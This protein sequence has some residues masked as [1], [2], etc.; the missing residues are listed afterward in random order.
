MSKSRKKSEN[1][2]DKYE[3]LIDDSKNE[4][5]ILK[6]YVS[7]NSPQSDRA[8][9]NLKK[10]CEENLKG[11]YALEIIDLYQKPELAKEANLIVVP[12]L[13]KKLPLPIRRLIGDL[14]NI[15]SV[16]I[17]LDIQIESGKK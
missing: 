5:Y 7:G 4:Q 17:G 6:L 14:S 16:L 13:V 8:I 11:R 15:D 10:I 9:Y 1:S 3:H 12:T 2:S